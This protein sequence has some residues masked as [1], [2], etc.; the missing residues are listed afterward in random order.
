MTQDQNAAEQLRA[1][2]SVCEFC[3]GIG[4]N[5]VGSGLPYV[6]VG[7]R[8]LPDCKYCHGSGIHIADLTTLRVLPLL[9]RLYE[10][11]ENWDGDKEFND[12]SPT[13]ALIRVLEQIKEKP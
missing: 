3:N 13:D 11:V 8:R 6:V 4:Y 1:V 9:L 10:A 7:S 5:V 2:T 12:E